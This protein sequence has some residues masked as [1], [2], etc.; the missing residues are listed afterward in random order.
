MNK[1]ARIVSEALL[2]INIKVVVVGGKRYTIPSPTIHRIAGAAY[3]LSGYTLPNKADFTMADVLAT[4]NKSKE[5]A[6][7]LS[8]FIQ[9]D[10]KLADEL[11]KGTISE[12]VSALESAYSM[13][14]TR[15]FMRAVGISKCVA[16]LAARPK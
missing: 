2:G 9:D 7:A 15:D 8:W 13:I 11:S 4:I 6:S 12:L 5:L 1:G 3:H 14:D 16:E 10:E